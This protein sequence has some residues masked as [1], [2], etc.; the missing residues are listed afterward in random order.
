MK[1]SRVNC[2][3]RLFGSALRKR[4][5]RQSR[6][7]FLHRAT[8]VVFG[9]AGVAIAGRVGLEYRTAF[10]Q[11]GGLGWQA[12]GLVGNL[13]TDAAGGCPRP[14]GGAAGSSWSKCCKDPSCGLWVSCTYTDFCSATVMRPAACDAGVPAGVDLAIVPSWCGGGSYHCTEYR[15]SSGGSAT[16]AM[17]NNDLAADDS[18]AIRVCPKA[19]G[20]QC[21]CKETAPGSGTWKCLDGTA[22]FPP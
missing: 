20:G 2:W 19:G 16:E 21:L 4:S 12:C 9:A 22:A 7:G 1:R 18:C 8:Q 13:C 15:C 10:A 17:C 5:A 11:A 3:D 6:R 14:A